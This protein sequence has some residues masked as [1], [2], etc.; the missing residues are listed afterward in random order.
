VG[1]RLHCA[2]ELFDHHVEPAQC[3]HLELMKLLLEVL[4]TLLSGQLDRFA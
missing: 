3:A 4:A 1:Q 2:V